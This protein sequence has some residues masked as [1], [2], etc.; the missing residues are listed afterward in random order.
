MP[1]PRK[2]G[3]TLCSGCE[4]N[5]IRVR[6]QCDNCRSK[7][8]IQRRRERRLQRRTLRNRI[9]FS[10]QNQPS[11]QLTAP[12]TPND[13]NIVPDENFVPTPCGHSTS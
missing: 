6:K 5:W 4:E 12:P 10:L 1:R 13:E 9:Q 3:L 2:V 8:Y 7:G 11:P